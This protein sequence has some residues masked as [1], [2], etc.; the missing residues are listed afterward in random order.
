VTDAIDIA[1]RR[2]LSNIVGRIHKV[3]FSKPVD[4]MSMNGSGSPYIKDLAEKL[5][6]LRTEILGRMSLG[7][8]G[9]EW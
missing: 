4:P 2:E 8:M 3:D 5:T 9:R 7:E 6:F 1:V